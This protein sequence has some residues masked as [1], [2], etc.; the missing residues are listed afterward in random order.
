MRWYSAFFTSTTPVI[1][2]ATNSAMIC[3]TAGLT[4]WEKTAACSTGCVFHV[5]LVLAVIAS[6][7]LFAWHIQIRFHAAT[8]GVFAPLVV[9]CNSC[10]SLQSHLV[11]MHISGIR[12]IAWQRHVQGSQ[13]FVYFASINASLLW[14]SVYSTEGHTGIENV[15]CLPQ[16]R[17]HS[18]TPL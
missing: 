4:F 10:S 11:V 1:P 18:Q 15:G 7:W 3:A 5:P 9:V 2:L 17:V 8:S 16:W 12:C 6:T 14:A 13:F